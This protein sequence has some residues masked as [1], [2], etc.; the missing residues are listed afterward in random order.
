MVNF[1]GA[2]Y[3]FEQK[4]VKYREDLFRVIH[5]DYYTSFELQIGKW[6]ILKLLVEDVVNLYNLYKNNYYCDYNLKKL[7]DFYNFLDFLFLK[8]VSQYKNKKV[9]IQCSDLKKMLVSYCN[10]DSFESWLNIKI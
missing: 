2:S 1:L 7:E 9:N 4:N 10:N 8:F 6:T 3:K 5:S